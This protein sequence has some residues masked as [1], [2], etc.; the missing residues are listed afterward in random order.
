MKEFTFITTTF[1]HEKYIIEH[2]E[3]IKKI[4]QDYGNEIEIDLVLADDCS[5]DQTCDFAKKWLNMNHT[6]FRNILVYT[7][8]ENIGTVKN[9]LKAI[10]NV[11]T[12]YFKELGGDDK[13]YGTN[14]FELFE[15]NTFLITPI[16]PFDFDTFS[17]DYLKTSYKLIYSCR[18]NKKMKK[19]LSFCCLIPA[20]GVFL[21]SDI[22]RDENL[23]S[24]LSQFK[25]IED[26]PTWYYLLNKRKNKL[27]I[28]VSTQ[29]YICYRIGSG[30]STQAKNV[31]TDYV[32]DKKRIGYIINPKL[33]KYPR[34][35]NVYKYIF[36]IK[37]SLL[38]FK[39]IKE[40]KE[41]D[42]M[43]EKVKEREQKNGCK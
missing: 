4:I 41:I 17:F 40:F 2:L 19:L 3:S 16:I 24:F 36:V 5:T 43:Y 34:I 9:L 6:L 8:E 33:E 12:R 25:L 38:K 26:Y 13:Y 30:V 31:N 1:N 18:T 32:M 42:V 7:N 23:K 37:R 14:I 20:P 35:F 11:K 15:E 21:D 10:E 28:N 22:Y 39:Q 27:N 29:P